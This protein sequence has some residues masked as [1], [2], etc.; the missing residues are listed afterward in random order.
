M[1][2]EMRGVSPGKGLT[3]NT[4]IFVFKIF[5]SVAIAT[6]KIRAEVIKF[7]DLYHSLPNRGRITHISN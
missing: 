6:G 7:F 4:N 3:K 1:S 2:G 5:K